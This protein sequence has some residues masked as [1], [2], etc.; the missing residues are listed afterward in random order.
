MLITITITITILY[1]DLWKSTASCNGYYNNQCN[2]QG[3]MK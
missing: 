3:G 1:Y 2:N